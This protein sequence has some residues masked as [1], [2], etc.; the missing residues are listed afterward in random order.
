MPSTN[1]ARAIKP[2]AIT[3]LCPAHSLIISEKVLPMPA[4]AMTLTI[5]PTEQSRIA[6]ITMF[7]APRDMASITALG[8][9]LLGEN[10][11]ETM[12]AMMLIP[13]A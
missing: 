12:T 2:M 13:A 8:P 1:E 4:V 6:V 9:I 10:Q 3:M 11:E 7:L 5:S